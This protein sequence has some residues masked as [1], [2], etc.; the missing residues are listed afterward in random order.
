M[1]WAM[2]VCGCVYSMNGERGL[3]FISEVKKGKLSLT[4]LAQL[5]GYCIA[6][7]TRYGLLIGIDK[8]VTGGFE[9]IV[10]R[11]PHLLHFKLGNSEYNIGVGW[12]N[13]NTNEFNFDDF[14]KINSY[15]HLSRHI[16]MQLR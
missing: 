5:I 16:A 6:S 4:H 3:L 12:W 7:K 11:N 10:R 14:G 8:R 13:S 15:T 1:G 9:N 2:W